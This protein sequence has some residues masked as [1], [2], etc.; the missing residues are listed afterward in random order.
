MNDMTE[1]LYSTVSSV[2]SRG[3]NSAMT[4]TQNIIFTIAGWTRMNFDLLPKIL[5][6]TPAGTSYRTLIHFA[7]SIRTGKFA[8]Y[9]FQ[10]ETKNME[11]YGTPT[12][13]EYRMAQVT[14][15]VLLYWGESDWLSQPGEV[16]NI[17][18][19]FPNLVDTV[20]VPH[21]SF[22][23]LDFLWGKDADS[24]LYRPA[25]EVMGQFTE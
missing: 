8:Q 6:H 24:L 18:A 7:Q 20:R 14:C 23:H 19:K 3:N 12:P 10:S 25:M 1:T 15:P 17:A 11:N 16:A 21:P 9:D 13:P 2:V 4:T 22:N 5:G